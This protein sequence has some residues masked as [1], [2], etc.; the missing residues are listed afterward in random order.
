V[1][2]PVVTRAPNET[3]G[4][5]NPTA[6]HD[7]FTHRIERA[8]PWTEPGLRVTRLRLL[9]DPGFPMWDVSY[10]HGMIGDEPVRV[11]LPFGQLP[12]GRVSSAIID[13][14]KA[15]G[16]YAKRLG[17]LDSISTLS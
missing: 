2:V 12:K 14:A 13:H 10:C 8:V 5:D 7:D 1:T 16:V 9:T 6:Y 15:D 11:I 4:L 17:I 3:N